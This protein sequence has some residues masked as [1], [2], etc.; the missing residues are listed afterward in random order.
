MSS[1]P[2][3]LPQPELPHG[4]WCSLQAFLPEKSGRVVCACLTP[5]L[6]PDVPNVIL[7]GAG[8]DI[9]RRGRMLADQSGAIPV[10]LKNASDDWRYAGEFEVERASEIDADIAPWQAHAGR[11]DVRI[12][13]HM[14]KA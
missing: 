2:H 14:R 4:F 9:Y 11:A 10:F 7:V 6:N 3:S 5:K 1:P 13:I 12:V 8:R